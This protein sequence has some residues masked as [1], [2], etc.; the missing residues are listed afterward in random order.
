MTLE[1]PRT[2]DRILQDA[3][4][5]PAPWRDRSILLWLYAS[6]WS[7]TRIADELG[8]TPKKVAGYMRAYGIVIR[9][10]GRAV[11]MGRRVAP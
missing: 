1:P 2:H 3:R 6:G 5:H 10:R 11:K 4:D 7:Q 8:T 9:D